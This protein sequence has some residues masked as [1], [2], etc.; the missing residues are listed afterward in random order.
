MR[1]SVGASFPADFVR[2]NTR[3]ARP[4]A[5]NWIWRYPASVRVCGK[6]SN[7]LGN[8]RKVLRQQKLGFPQ[9]LLGQRSVIIARLKL[10]M[11]TFRINGPLREIIKRTDRRGGV[12][13]SQELVA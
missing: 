2:G 6:L 3:P 5:L 9:S 10:A 12:F 4:V 8:H 13:S 1:P 11:A 7:S